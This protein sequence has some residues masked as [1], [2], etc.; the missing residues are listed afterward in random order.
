MS[1]DTTAELDSASLHN[2]KNGSP[3]TVAPDFGSLEPAK[4]SHSRT[5]TIRAISGREPDTEVVPELIYH[6]NEAV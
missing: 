1:R 2:S 4:G 6:L 5:A 3:P